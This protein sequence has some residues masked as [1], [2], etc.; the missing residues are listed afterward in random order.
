MNESNKTKQNK[1][2]ETESK[3]LF[4]VLELIEARIL[5]PNAMAIYLGYYSYRNPNGKAWPTQECIAKQ[6]HVS[7]REVAKTVAVLREHGIISTS[8]YGYGKKNRRTNMKFLHAD[9]LSVERKRKAGIK[10]PVVRRKSF[11]TAKSAKVLVEKFKGTPPSTER[12]WWMPSEDFDSVKYESDKDF[13]EIM[14]CDAR[15]VG[16]EIKE[17]FPTKNGSYVVLGNMELLRKYFPNDKLIE[18]IRI[19]ARSTA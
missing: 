17:R 11:P 5:K 8:P 6:Y 12:K 4:K 15:R 14:N 19:N 10:K 13:K 1:E 16:M 18:Q 7:K 9:Q 2:S 3:H